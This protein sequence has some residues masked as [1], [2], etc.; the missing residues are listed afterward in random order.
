V[1]TLTPGWG[2][3]AKIIGG[4]TVVSEGMGTDVDLGEVSHSKEGSLHLRSYTRTGI[5][6]AL[7]SVSKGLLELGKGVK[8]SGAM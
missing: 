3:K 2:G 8:S 5:P 1:L 4:P 6:E 7:L